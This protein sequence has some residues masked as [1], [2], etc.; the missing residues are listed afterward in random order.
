MRR[1]YADQPQLPNL[2]LAD[3]F[4]HALESRNSAWRSALQ[5]AIAAGIPTP[6]M[7]AS[8]MY[9]DAYRTGRLPANLVQAQRDYFG[10]HTYRR[11]DKDGTFHTTWQV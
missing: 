5:T 8:L 11:V 7:S 2:I 1:I 3:P 10:S 6:A 4:R 9:Y